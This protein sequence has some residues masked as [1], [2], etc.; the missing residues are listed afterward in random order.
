MINFLILLSLLFFAS[1][2]VEE[3]E[4]VQCS[5]IIEETEILDAYRVTCI[6]RD[7]KFSKEYIGKTSDFEIAP[8]EKCDE[9]IGFPLEQ[10]PD[11]FEFWEEVRKEINKVKQRNK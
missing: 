1:C 9:S 3:I 4:T 8:I 11:V 2:D 5:P 6:C 7:Y 10:Y